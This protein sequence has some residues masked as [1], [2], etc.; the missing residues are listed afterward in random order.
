VRP[1][2]KVKTTMTRK[3]DDTGVTSRRTVK[4]KPCDAAKRIRL[5]AVASV[6]PGPNVVISQKL[7]EKNLNVSVRG[8]FYEK[9]S[10]RRNRHRVALLAS[11][12]ANEAVPLALLR[13]R[14]S[15]SAERCPSA[16]RVLVVAPQFEEDPNL[17][18]VKGKPV[19]FKGR[20]HLAGLAQQKAR[21]KMKTKGR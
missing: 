10:S 1:S 9:A 6:A 8:H 12:S 4:K 13:R 15:S 3:L 19:S 7:D 18:A 5:S 2:V 17:Q 14:S 16:N 21:M 20:S 11:G